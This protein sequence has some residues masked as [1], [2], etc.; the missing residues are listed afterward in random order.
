MK[1]VHPDF[2]YK[3]EFEENKFNL[4]ILEDKK[5]FL[6]YTEEIYNQCNISEEMGG[7]VL[8]DDKGKIQK[9][10]KVADII[11]DIYNLD[12][13]N[14]KIL[15]KLYSN[16]RELSNQDELYIETGKIVSEI[17]RYVDLVTNEAE[18]SLEYSVEFDV[19]ELFKITDVKFESYSS[20]IIERLCEYVN[21]SSQILGKRIFIFVNMRNFFDRDV[22]EE[23]YRYLSYKK[24]FAI[25]I[26][27]S[28]DYTIQDYEKVF[29][30]DSDLCEI[31]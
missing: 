7:F 10:S 5:V 1:L 28:I 2:E 25:M 8:S 9:L 15:T 20:T 11:V 23:F 29:V 18:Y 19:S 22:I 24:I 3:I 13:N 4:I 27:N 30:L 6:K 12:I 16:L 31:Y 14:R 17:I 21:V 26:E